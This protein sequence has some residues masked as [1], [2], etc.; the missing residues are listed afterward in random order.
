MK[1]ELDYIQVEEALGG[2]QDWFLDPFMKG[3][4]CAAVT[5]CDLCIYFARQKG[6][7]ELYPFDAKN[8]AKKEYI[9]FSKQMKPYLHPRRQG[10]DTLDIYLEGIRAYWKNVNCCSLTA[11][12][13]PGTA[14]FDMARE[15]VKGQIDQDLPIPFLTLHHKNP[16]L[17]DYVWH[18]YNLAGYEE[19]LEGFFVKAVTYGEAEWLDLSELWDTGFERKGGMI[20]LAVV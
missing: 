17:K 16:K 18:W 19:T 8:P 12:G 3:G 5:A 1:K 15:A 14:D 20:L 4:G 11:E 13:F 9:Q 10:I 2:N 7:N 6:L